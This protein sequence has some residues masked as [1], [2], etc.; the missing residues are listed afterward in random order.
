M[1]E[2]C[3]AWRAFGPTQALAGAKLIVRLGSIH[4]LLGA[5]GAGK[6]TLLRVLAG[7]DRLD[8][9]TVTWNGAMHVPADVSDAEARGVTM[10]HQ[11]VR[12]IATL[13]VEDNLL[14]GRYPTTARGTID[15]K[16]ARIEARRA[17]DRVGLD[18]RGDEAVEDL[19]LAARQRVAI[20]RAM[21]APIAAE[22][23]RLLILDEPTSSL[24]AREVKVLFDL[25][26]RLASDGAAVLFVGHS[27]REVEDVCTDVTVLRNGATVLESKVGD[28]TR[29]EWIDAMLGP[30]AAVQAS[31]QPAVSRVDGVEGL[32]L[33]SVC[34]DK[35]D[36][37]T[38]T[39]AA[40]E[41]IG[42][43]GLLGSGR[44]E[45]LRLI[46]GVDRITEGSV[47][48][49]G[50]SLPKMSLHAAQREGIAFLPEDRRAEGLCPELS[51][52]DNLLLAVQ[53]R[54]GWLTRLPRA[55]AGETLQRLVEHTGL[56]VACLDRP[57][58]TLSG[59][60]QQKVL[61]VR[62]LLLGPKVLLLDEPHRGI[63]VGAVAVID[64]L[65]R[66]QQAE[67]V[68]VIR[69]D[70]DIDALCAVCDRIAV[71]VDGKVVGQVESLGPSDVRTRMA[72]GAP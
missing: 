1:L 46:A 32:A 40:G 41:S 37:T 57:V 19:S 45:L 23:P 53:S 44:S 42:L 17:L 61:L 49:R 34:S 28:A 58:S 35:I 56:P 6:S 24:T 64:A 21:H 5:N 26:R 13:S 15:R 3:G 31:M 20:A 8:R 16:L 12:L 52:R 67:G 51:V 70:P 11:E 65:I 14:M 68:S 48:V 60:N 30:S 38:M 29:R 50:R 33:Q 4:A 72:Q 59:G 66:E 62:L 39:V 43:A 22:T 55:V 71:L 18:L 27:L 36:R 63:D 25:M 2:V 54:Q 10:V 9:G 47:T 69:T 7:A